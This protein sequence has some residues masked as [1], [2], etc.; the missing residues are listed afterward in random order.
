MNSF[1]ITTERIKSQFAV[2]V[3]FF[4]EHVQPLDIP[5]VLCCCKRCGWI[6]IGRDTY[7]LHQWIMNHLDC[8][9]AMLC[10]DFPKQLEDAITA[11][12]ERRA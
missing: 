10:D 7:Q 8:K 2:G 6:W 11:R 1:T 12:N 3:R 4:N 5:D 9:G